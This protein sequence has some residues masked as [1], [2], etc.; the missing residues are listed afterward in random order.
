LSAGKL[1]FLD[2]ERDDIE[3][4]EAAVSSFPV[5]L[6]GAETL[7]FKLEFDIVDFGLVVSSL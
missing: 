3:V 6:V 1:D 4:E 5:R 7:S 2:S